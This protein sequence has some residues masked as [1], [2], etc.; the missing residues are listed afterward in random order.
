MN[1][2]STSRFVAALTSLSLSNLLCGQPEPVV[3]EYLSL[4]RTVAAVASTEE[5][6]A[7]IAG[8]ESELRSNEDHPDY[9]AMMF[10]LGQSYSTLGDPGTAVDVFDDLRRAAPPDARA[11]EMILFELGLVA[12]HAGSS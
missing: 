8:F 11:D 4:K 3:E 10:W 5:R 2:R 7:H 12:L 6:L 1:R 9:S